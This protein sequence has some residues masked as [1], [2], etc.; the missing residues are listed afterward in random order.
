MRNGAQLSLAVINCGL[1]QRDALEQIPSHIRTRCVS[2][3]AVNQ[4]SLYDQLERKLTNQQARIFLEAVW[5][6]P[7][8][9][10]RYALA[11]SQ[12]AALIMGCH[13]D[14][15]HCFR[16]HTGKLIRLF[17]KHG[18]TYTQSVLDIDDYESAKSFRFARRFSYD[19]GK[20]YTV[21]KTLDAAKLASSEKFLIPRFTHAYVCSE[22]DKQA[23]ET[24]FPGTRWTVVPNT[25]PL[26][27]PSR[28]TKPGAFT[29]VFVGQL[30]YPP[31]KDA[32]IFFCNRILP[33]LRGIASYPFRVLIAG[34]NP[35]PSLVQLAERNGLEVLADPVNLGPIYAQADAAIVPIRAGGGTRIKILE[36]FRCALP[37]VSTTI[38]AEGLELNPGNHVLIADSPKEFAES[39]ERLMWDDALR[40]RLGTAGRNLFIER[41]CEDI[42]VDIFRATLFPI[43]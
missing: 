14:V 22:I 33:I 18:I 15:I 30:S 41:F 3:L 36:A 7:V 37:V 16:L 34:R 40:Q 13:F 19:V 12:L 11:L 1:T 43:K 25:L 4:S 27:P 29:F 35:D 21:L 24:R 17:R 31:N 38:G 2:I 32:I 42:L 26:A 9:L 6:T 20:Q 8:A 28:K 10:S 23:L 5:P 39:C